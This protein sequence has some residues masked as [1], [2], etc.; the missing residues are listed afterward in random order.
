MI[1]NERIKTQ[2]TVIQEVNNEVT[3]AQEKFSGLE[4]AHDEYIIQKLTIMNNAIQNLLNGDLERWTI[5][6][7]ELQFF[8]NENIINTLTKKHGFSIENPSENMEIDVEAIQKS[9]VDL[10]K[11]L[12]LAVSEEEWDCADEINS[13]IEEKKQ[14]IADSNR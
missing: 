12:E 10:E 4:L 7:L 2:K 9:L 1:L 3:K 13:L 5:G 14:I 8:N 6:I 11:R